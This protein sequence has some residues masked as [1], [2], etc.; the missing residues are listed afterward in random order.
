MTIDNNSADDTG[1]VT[2]LVNGKQVAQGNATSPINGGPEN[3]R[4]DCG[5]FIMPNFF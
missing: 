5:L 1:R 3:L 2:L 4:D